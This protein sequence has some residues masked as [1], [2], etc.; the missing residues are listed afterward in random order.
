MQCQIQ[1]GHNGLV[2]N[3]I[4]KLIIV[5]RFNILLLILLIMFLQTILSLQIKHI[6]QLTCRLEGDFMYLI[7]KIKNW[8]IELKLF[9]DMI[10]FMEKEIQETM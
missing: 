7:K 1:L 10:K 2:H 6:Q 3:P 4:G 9:T 5:D 8:F